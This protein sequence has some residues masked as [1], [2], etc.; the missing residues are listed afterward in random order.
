MILDNNLGLNLYVVPT[1]YYV[2]VILKNCKVVRKKFLDEEAVEN[3]WSDFQL[4]LV[5][6]IRD[7]YKVSTSYILSLQ[8]EL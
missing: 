5:E 3:F 6:E 2:V 7:N 8:L 1:I 4:I